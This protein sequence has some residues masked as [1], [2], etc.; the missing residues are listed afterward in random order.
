M[1]GQME[2]RFKVFKSPLGNYFTFENMKNMRNIPKVF[3][4]DGNGKCFQ[5]DT[6]D[7]VLDGLK[8]KTFRLV[9]VITHN[10]YKQNE[11]GN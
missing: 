7:S 1:V 4:V 11:V 9:L 6:Q 2:S 5:S 3:K 10:Y 8:V